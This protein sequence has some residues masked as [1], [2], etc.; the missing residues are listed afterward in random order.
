MHC[1]L[2]F[3]KLFDLFDLLKSGGVTSTV[4]VASCTGSY[5]ATYDLVKIRLTTATL[6]KLGTIS[7]SINS[8]NNP[9]SFKP[10]STISLWTE[11]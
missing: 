8:I 2:Y 6:A 1:F 10:I 9:C 7:V 5:G 11:D 4:T 3:C